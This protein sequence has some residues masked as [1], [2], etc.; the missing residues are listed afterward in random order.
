M[1]EIILREEFHI[2]TARE[3]AAARA[4][5]MGFS[6]SAIGQIALAISEICQNVIRYAIEGIAQIHT[7]NQEKVL[8]IVITDKGPGILNL[9]QAMK[10]GFST[11]NTSIGVG[12]MAAKRSVDFFEVHTSTAGTRVVLE[13]YLPVPPEIFQY[14]VVSLADANYTVNGDDYLIKAFEGDKVLLAVIDG[15]GQGELAHQMAI[16]V[17]EIVKHNFRLPLN[18]LM[19]QCDLYLK[20]ADFEPGGVAMNLALLTPSH[21][22]YLSVGDTHG[23]LLHPHFTP[24]LSTEGRVGGHFMRSLKVL[25]YATMTAQY[26]VLC[27]DGISSQVEMESINWNQHPQDIAIQFF[28]AFNRPY[29][30]AT[31]LVG[32]YKKQ[33]P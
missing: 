26:L 14:G 12:L 7:R 13:K 8:R 2:D 25:Q 31:V 30:D 16:G 18:Q 24:L 22:Q 6:P 21:I 10:D 15:L 1:E 11:T 20:N 5:Q 9:A 33:S 19:E 27:T 3:I 29:G 17:K 23:Y 32:K 4:T 28:N